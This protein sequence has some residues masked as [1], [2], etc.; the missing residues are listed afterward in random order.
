MPSITSCRSC[1]K[2]NLSTILDLGE[3]PL[4]NALLKEDEPKNGEQL[5]PLTLVLCPTCF[6]L[7]ITENVDQELLYSNYFY[8]SSFS[9]EF[10]AHCKKLADRIMTEKK[11]S[12]ESLVIDIA[13]NDGYLL[14][15]YQKHKIPVLGIEP[16]QNIATIAENDGIHTINEFFCEALAKKLVGKGRRADII[17]A[18]NVVPHVE[19]QK[20]FMTGIKFLLKNEGTAI[21]EF[22]YAVDTLKKNEFDQ[23]Y[24]EH[25]CY[26][27]LT[28]FKNLCEQVGLSVSNVE[29]LSIHGG[30]LR[31]F[32]RHAKNCTPSKTV[33]DFLKE[34]E[35]QGLSKIKTYTEFAQRVENLRDE[36]I[37]LLKKLKDEGKRIAAYGASAKGCTLMHYCRINGELVDYIVD[38]STA[39]QGYFAPGTHLKIEPVEKLLEDQPDYVLLLTWNFAEEIMK[40]QR[41]YLE[42]GG[43]FIL[44]IPEPSIA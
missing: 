15:F 11:L 5:F 18:H 31:V 7:Q 2:K 33:S 8:R 13:S 36:L 41:E 17:H 21:I 34:E 19:N 16:A 25:K 26:F 1:G 44:P 37:A 14:K 24:H 35:S 9:D 23:I 3:T 39:K 38:R 10:L 43:R 30:S 6:L 4:A 27:S 29:R 40:Q 42:R 12:E 28:S 20:D 22:A 32:L